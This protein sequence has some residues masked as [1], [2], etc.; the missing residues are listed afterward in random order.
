MTLDVLQ[1]FHNEPFNKKPKKRLIDTWAED[2]NS[3][4]HF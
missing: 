2:T 3:T 4:K 1:H